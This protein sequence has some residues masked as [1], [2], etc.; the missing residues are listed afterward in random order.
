VARS[1]RKELLKVDVL[2]VGGGPAGIG[3]ALGAARTGVKTLLIETQGFFGGVAAWS[4]GMPINQMQPDSKPRSKVHE[5]VLEKLKVYGD[6]AVYVGQHQWYCNV[7]YLK[8]A[9]LDAL[10]QVGCEYLV[11]MSAA[12]TLME[13]N[14]V[15][16]VVVSTK[17]GLATISAKA[18][19]DCT[20]DADVAYF[21]GAETM[22]ETKEPRM[23][24]T[25]LLGMA[26]VSQEQIRSVK[27]KKIAKKARSKYPL[28]PKSWGLKPVSNCH[29]YWINHTG[30]RDI[31]QFDTTDPFEF[32]QAECVSRRQALQMIRAMREFGGEQLKDIEL[33]ATSPRIAVRETRRVKGG[34]VLTEEDAVKGRKFDDVIAWR[35]GYLDLMGYKFTK[36]KVH[37]VPYRSI[38]PEKVD[39]LLTAGRCISAT[40]VSMAAG[41]SM[42]NCVATGHAAGLAAAM[43][44]QKGIMPRELKVAQI[45]D[46]LRKDDVDLA[47]GGKTQVDIS[48]DRGV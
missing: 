37:D 21:A 47:R 5:L 12:D 46:A 40:H 28:I 23:P 30:T 11:H 34:Y 6:Q 10:D 26:N 15:T 19:V 4:L 48:G 29:H 44:A 42:G 9:V 25:L 35:S 22:M 8:V 24:S 14:R 18:V 16:G 7:D 36:M 17:Q 31:G 33:V 39:G 3:A 43:S 1:K 13:G 38:L 45:Q 20:G 2:V 32:S 27:I 41:K